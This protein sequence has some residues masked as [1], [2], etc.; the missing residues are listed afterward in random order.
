MSDPTYMQNYLHP[1]KKA[2]KPMMKVFPDGR[3]VLDLK[4]KAGADEYQ[5]RKLEM[6]DRQGKRCAL[7]ITDI[8]KQRQGRWPRNETQFD[9]ENGR[10]GGKQDDRIEVLDPET[11]KMKPQNGV[12]CPYCNSAKG[13]RRVPYLIDVP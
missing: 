11:G 4:T 12:V 10:G 6:W 3:E 8:C 2:P 7:Q 5:R 1:P 13:S 9:H